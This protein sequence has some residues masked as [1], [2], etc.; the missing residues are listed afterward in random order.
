MQT[1]RPIYSRTLWFNLLSVVA[2]VHA[3]ILA[4]PELKEF[5]GGYTGA[6]MITGAVI[7]AILRFRTTMPISTK[8]PPLN[9]VDKALRQDDIEISDGF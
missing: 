1:K 2:I 7:N 4:N 9:P 3:E 8:P 5:I 6:L